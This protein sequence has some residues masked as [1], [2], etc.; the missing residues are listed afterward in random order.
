[1]V[2]LPLARLTSLALLSMALVGCQSGSAPSSSVASTTPAAKAPLDPWL[3]TTLDPNVQTPALLWNGSLGFRIGRDGG[4]KGQPFFSIEEYDTS[5]EEKIRTLASPL[6]NGFLIDGKPLPITGEYR[7]TLDMKT[8]LLTTHFRSGGAVID[9][10][11]VLDPGK[12]IVGEEWTLAG[13][14][15]SGIDFDLG[16]YGKMA[17]ANLVAKNIEVGPSKMLGKFWAKAKIESTIK[18]D[19]VLTLANSP[20]GA[21]ILNARGAKISLSPVAAP[22]PDVVDFA[23][24]QQSAEKTWANRWKTDIEIDGPVED[25]QAVRSFLFY[26]R[27]AVRHDNQADLDVMSISPFGLSDAM[28]NGH[29]FWDADIWVFPALALL[30]PVAAKAFPDYRFATIVG[31]ASEHRG[32]H[33]PWESSISGK[34]TVPGSSR[35]ELH[36]SG[37]VAWMLKQA[38][39]LGL[40]DPAHAQD[41]L[42]GVDVFYKSI[43]KPVHGTRELGI[44]KVMS[45]DENHIGDNDLYTNLLAQW[46]SDGGKWVVH[47]PSDTAPVYYLPKDATSF[48]T[49]GN[50]PLKAYKQAAAVLSIYPLQYPPAEAEAKTM[51]E[52]FAGKVIKNGPAMSDSVHALIW[53]RLGEREKAYETWRTSWQPFT[54]HP[55]MLFSEKR[56]KATTYFTTGAGGCLQTVLFGFLG[57]RLDSV[58]ER[59]AA[60]STKLQGDCWLSAKPNFPRQWKSVRLRNFTV[61]GRKFSLTATHLPAGNDAVKVTQGD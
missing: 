17:G 46:V 58:S 21:L 33:Y 30:D 40:T 57:F 37:D 49:Y 14:V 34:E 27:S 22:A 47:G 60:W 35:H 25:Q 61:L 29:V 32:V 1:M 3:L 13:G 2:R 6:P 11:A 51:M 18:V 42:H 53:A 9:C 52:R 43:S 8:S 45:P 23:D 54:D 41:V 24:V 38:A 50:D 48:L 28:Y 16:P 7:Q 5:G 56:T 26:L 19:Y 15:S 12:R 20:N 36:I 55:L 4:A 44:P 39:A 59:E 31:A 10:V